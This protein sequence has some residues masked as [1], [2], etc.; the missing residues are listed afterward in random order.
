[1][2]VMEMVEALVGRRR[3]LVAPGSKRFNGT[4]ACEWR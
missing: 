2:I 1:M 4:V 3:T